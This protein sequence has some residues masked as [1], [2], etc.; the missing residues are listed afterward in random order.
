MGSW[1]PGRRGWWLSNLALLLVTTATSARAGQDRGGSGPSHWGNI[2]VVSDSV[3]TLHEGYRRSAW[4]WPLYV[5]WKLVSLPFE[6]VHLGGKGAV[7]FLDD[8]GV[9]EWAARNYPLPVAAGFNASFTI[10]RPGAVDGLG[11]AIN[12]KNEAFLGPRNRIQLRVGGTV[13]GNRT[14]RLGLSSFRGAGGEWNLG[15]GYRKQVSAR[16]FGIGPGSRQEN[17]SF[18]TGRTSWAGGLFRR[19]LPMRLAVEVGANFTR[20]E[21]DD[22]AEA[23]EKV[24]IGDRFAG[25][26]PTGY[27]ETSDGWQFSLALEHDTTE[28]R[29]RPTRGGIQKVS[30]GYF[31]PTSRD[32]TDFFVYRGELQQFF[33]LWW[34]RAFAARVIYSWTDEEDIHFQRLMT[35]DDPDVM[36]GYDDLRWRDRGMTLA[37]FEYRYPVWAYKEPHD[38]GLDAYV[39]FDW[40]QVFSSHRQIALDALTRSYGGGFRFVDAGG[41]SAR[42]E[43]GVSREDVVFRIG[44]SQTFQFEE[45]GYYSGRIPV[46]LR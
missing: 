14:A 12:L 46:P 35:N 28:D 31:S 4:E 19:P 1:N 36:R 13:K 11:G 42:V 38:T 5:P 10:V 3:Q 26:L 41:F 8:R 33:R 18:Y 43:V 25:N 29:G 44:G 37:M 9:I 32:E 15:V 20:L 39:F 40:G 34:E 7:V 45:G 16:Y 23:D 27:A 22:P 30:V 6:L 21:N 2:P 17:E 24:P